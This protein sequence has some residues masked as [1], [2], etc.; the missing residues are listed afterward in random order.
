M[1]NLTCEDAACAYR[2][3]AAANPA[4]LGKLERNDV[5][6][7][8]KLTLLQAMQISA[9]RDRIAWQYSHGFVDILTMGVVADKSFNLFGFAHGFGDYKLST[10]NFSRIFQTA[11]SSAN[12]VP[13]KPPKFVM[14]RKN[15]SA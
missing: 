9:M 10:S 6:E 14:P 5:R 2:A 13:R 11:I 1:D 8:P 4:G 12:T 3:I 15:S 7:P